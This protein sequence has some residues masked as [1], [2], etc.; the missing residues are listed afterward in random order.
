[1]AFYRPCPHCG[2]NLDPGERCDCRMDEKK[3]ADPVERVRPQAPNSTVL[4][5]SS[6]RPAVKSDR[7]WAYV[8]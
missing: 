7:R 5:L 6:I 4:S 8:K 2:A 1:M 3:E